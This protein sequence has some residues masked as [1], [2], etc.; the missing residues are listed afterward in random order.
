MEGDGGVECDELAELGHVDAIAI[1]IAD[2]RG[3]GADDDLRRLG[4]GEDFQDGFLEGRAADDGVVEDDEV[5]AGFHGTVGDVVDVGDELVAAFLLGD[6]GAHLDVLVGDF[7]AARPIPQD[8]F[9]DLFRSQRAG[10]DAIQDLHP[11]LL[12]AVEA[13]AV[14][15][16]VVGGFCGVRDEGEDSLVEGIADGG[17]DLIHE[18]GTHRLALAIDL[19]VVAT[20]EVD[21]LKR[22]GRVF[23]RG[24]ELGI[25]NGAIRL[26]D[27]DG[28]RIERL[29]IAGLGFE[30]GHQRHTLGGEGDDVL[31]DEHVAGADAARVAHDKHVAIA[32][33]AADCVSAVPR[34][35][36]LRDDIRDVE[37]G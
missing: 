5:V 16:A 18:S 33:S 15:H 24:V 22:A 32:D 31:G 30:N 17:D 9:I 37:G 20:R 26:D 1:R 27:D 8:E 36:R 7:L 25:G 29:D 4:A 10:S 23:L 6:E 34:F 28:A 12:A 13:E 3:G 11:H 2:L 14:H 21:L 35:R 19:R